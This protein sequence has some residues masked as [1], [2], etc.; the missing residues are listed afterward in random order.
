M[1]FGK[2]GLIKRDSGILELIQWNSGFWMATCILVFATGSKPDDGSPKQPS[3]RSKNHHH[4]HPELGNFTFQVLR[5]DEDARQN[6]LDDWDVFG[7]NV[8]PTTS[9]Q[10]FKRHPFKLLLV[11]G[12]VA[13]PDAAV[14][15]A[16]TL[17]QFE[18]TTQRPFAAELKLV[19]LLGT[20][21]PLWGCLRFHAAPLP[22][23]PVTSLKQPPPANQAWLKSN[24]ANCPQSRKLIWSRVESYPAAQQVHFAAIQSDER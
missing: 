12:S 16:R 20:F 7:G 24:K 8:T 13:I 14:L 4:M 17:F 18:T 5:E 22:F 3:N 21:F 23:A 2:Q 19:P 1:R 11:L 10:R 15:R 9:V 6:N